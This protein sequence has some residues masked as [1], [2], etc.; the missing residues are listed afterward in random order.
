M[1]LEG[2]IKSAQHM[3]CRYDMDLD[4]RL[5]PRD[6]YDL[7]LELNLALPYADY[8]RMVDNTF[9]YAG[10]WQQPCLLHRVT[11]GG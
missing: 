11:L 9:V 3:F 4:M 6:F 5:G 1:Q 2:S 7:M 10:E 8:Q